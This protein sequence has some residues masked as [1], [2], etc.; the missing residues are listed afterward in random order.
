MTDP[1]E[2]KRIN[3]QAVHHEVNM[4]EHKA[5]DDPELEADELAEADDGPAPGRDFHF[6]LGTVDL[7]G[8]AE[9]EWFHGFMEMILDKTCAGDRIHVSF[10]G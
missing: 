7:N 5:Q 1:D 2:L 9:L 10:W 4:S 8:T 6:D 3:P